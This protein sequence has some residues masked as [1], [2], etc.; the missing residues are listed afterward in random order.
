MIK[1]IA[2]WLTLLIVIPFGDF[3]STA[4]R[5]EVHFGPT[6][7]MLPSPGGYCKI[8]ESGTPASI[9]FD[10]QKEG[11]LKAGNKLLAFWVDCVWL[12]AFN[13]GSKA[14]V[15]SKWA[16]VVAGLSGPEGLE[17]V[18]PNLSRKS[19]LDYMLKQ[20]GSFT[21]SHKIE[22]GKNKANKA[23]KEANKRVLSNPDIVKAGEIIP[24][25][26][27]EI[28]DSIHVGYIQSIKG[29]SDSMLVGT[30]FSSTL[31]HG[32]IVHTYFYEEYEDEDSI[33]NI[34]H[35][36]KTYSARLVSNNK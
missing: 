27:L 26:V 2:F 7:F 35:E 16:L 20:A 11:Q 1:Q 4:E 32:V 33:K 10:W 12:A 14:E 19:Y 3:A 25:G 9:F 36:A 34:L 6:K 18:F 13:N 5:N 23:I 15:M 8:R 21:D 29:Q 28:S 22:V 30:L 17:Q 31:I 24:L